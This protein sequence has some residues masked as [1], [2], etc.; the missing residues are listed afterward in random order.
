M[1]H[2]EEHIYRPHLKYTRYEANIQG[3]VRRVGSKR[4]TSFP[5]LHAR[6]KLKHRGQ[7]KE[8]N[9][10][11]FVWECYRGILQEYPL[12]LTRNCHINNLERYMI[13]CLVVL[14]QMGCNVIILKVI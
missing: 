10:S 3:F 5:K 14:L 9:R 13:S 2:Y 4:I 12:H 11:A 6:L 8:I 7:I 1:P